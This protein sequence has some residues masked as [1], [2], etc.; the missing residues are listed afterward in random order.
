[1]CL[2]NA[3]FA[4]N[5]KYCNKIIFKCMNSAVWLIFNKI[6]VKKE[7]CGSSEQCMRPIEQYILS[8]KRLKCVHKKKGKRKRNRWNT[9]QTHNK[10]L[11]IFSPSF[12]IPLV[13][14]PT[15]WTLSH[16][17]CLVSPRVALYPNRPSPINIIF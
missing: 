9:I 16:S 5:W 7:V 13:F 1:M 4:E 6:F 14:N 2:D 12:S 8:P 17:I 11:N 3:Y 15:K 10:S